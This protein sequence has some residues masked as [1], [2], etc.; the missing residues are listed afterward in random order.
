MII[1]FIDISVQVIVLSGTT[2]DHQLTGSIS[3]CAANNTHIITY[4]E[5][6]LTID[7][8]LRR[9]VRWLFAI[10]EVPFTVI[11]S[12]LFKHFDLLVDVK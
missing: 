2:T 5:R 3:L 12:D 7:L 8:E 4:G 1:S 6:S 11:C 10:A 9:L